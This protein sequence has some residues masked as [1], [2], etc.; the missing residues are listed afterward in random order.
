MD[1]S[2]PDF[3]VSTKSTSYKVGQPVTFDFKG[4]A[5]VITFNSGEK[6]DLLMSFASQTRFGSQANQLSI[7]VSTDFNGKFTEA[8]VK[9]ATWTNVSSRFT[10]STNTTLLSSG[11]R[12]I[13]DLAQSGKPLYV[14]FKY[15]GQA[16]P[17][18]TQR[19]WWVN[20]LKIDNALAGTTNSVL[21]HAAA[22]WKYVNFAQNAPGAGWSQV[23]DGRIFFNPN[24]TVLASEGWAIAKPIEPDGLKS[25]PAPIKAMIDS[26]MQS[27]DYTFLTPGEY[28]VTFEA[29]NANR[30]D[31]KKVTRTVQITITP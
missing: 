14:A 5:D 12:S 6:G 28:S 29:A 22:D 8:D 10:F 11:V 16:D 15:V 26:Q 30:F 24:E 18:K 9:A 17:A 2:S 27:Y 31:N 19:N 20:N 23:A 1:I 13:S 7:H 21:V 4:N 25:S 3:E